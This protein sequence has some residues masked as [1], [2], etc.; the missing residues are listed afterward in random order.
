MDLRFTEEQEMLKTSAKDF[1]AAECPKTKVRE[2]Q[3]DKIGYSPELWKKMAELG[4][5]GLLIPEAYQGMGLSFQDGMVLV[6]EVGKGVAP[7]P[8]MSTLVA[9]F[10]I[11]EGGS[12]AQKKEF[13]PKISSGALK[14]SLAYLETNGKYDASAVTLKATAKGND[15]VLNGTKM[16]VEMAH[17]SD[18]LICAA[19][20]KEGTKTEDGVTLFIVNAK[21]PGIAI[22]VIPT[23][24]FDKLCEVKFTNVSV[25]KANILGEIDKGWKIM[26]P[27]LRKA[28]L[29][30]SAASVGGM[31]VAI[32]MTVAYAKERVQYER[33]IGAFQALQH[34]MADM[35]IAMQTSRYLVYEAGWMES[36]G[37]PND[38]EASMAKAY[39]NDAYKL[40]SKWGIRLHGGIGTSREHDVSLCYLQAKANDIAYGGSDYHNELVAEK[41]GLK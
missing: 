27:T 34:L 26:K 19:R 29:M 28:G 13:L 41:I 30:T 12:E 14:F 9:S 21:S 25:P 40:V 15:F 24:A 2:L 6:E 22:E 3:Q 39:T 17:V 35:W 16:F 33:P 1:L 8:F 10:A 32:D 31:Q 36:N 37:L 5:M 20:T 7:G 18:Y 11:V 38:K 4:W 23:T